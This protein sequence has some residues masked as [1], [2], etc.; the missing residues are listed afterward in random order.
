MALP[1]GKETPV[2][3]LETLTGR[4]WEGSSQGI[5]FVWSKS[6]TLR[7][8]NF[9]KQQVTRISELPTVRAGPY[10]GL[11]VNPDGRTMLYLQLD[12]GRTNIMVVN[13]FH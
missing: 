3:G 11:S 9:S 6:T 8:L 2:A 4:L 12:P 13:K 1:D 7:F 10:R 5:Y